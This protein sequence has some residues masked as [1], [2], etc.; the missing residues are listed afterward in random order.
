MLSLVSTHTFLIRIYLK[1]GHRLYWKIHSRM[2]ALTHDMKTL[3]K[4]FVSDS[5]PTRKCSSSPRHNLLSSH[6]RVRSKQTKVESWLDLPFYLQ[7]IWR[8]YPVPSVPQKRNI[9]VSASWFGPR[10]QSRMCV[11]Q[12]L[13]NLISR[14]KLN[15][16]DRQSPKV[17]ICRS[18]VISWVSNVIFFPMP[19]LEAF[20]CVLTYFYQYQMKSIN[21]NASFLVL[22]KKIPQK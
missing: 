22:I 14:R 6:Q 19:L 4:S 1:M 17:V 15:I 20:Q 21:Q 8:Y 7:F 9:V 5:F 12:L 13:E 11:F 3:R 18:G 10:T 2:I 16:Y